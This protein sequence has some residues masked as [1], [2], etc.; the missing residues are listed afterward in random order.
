MRSLTAI[1][2][3][4][5]PE[6]PPEPEDGPGVSAGGGRW[7]SAPAEGDRRFATI[8]SLITSSCRGVKESSVIGSPSD[9]IA[10]Q[11]GRENGARSGNRERGRW[12]K[13]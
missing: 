13:A 9:A 8:S 3:K 10:G 5:S 2:P 1:Q 6:V 7:I 11:T 4:D 12:F